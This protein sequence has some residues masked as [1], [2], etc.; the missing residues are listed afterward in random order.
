MAS[1]FIIIVSLWGW[2]AGLC[3]L[4]GLAAGALFVVVLMT[5]APSSAELWGRRGE[6]DG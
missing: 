6:N 3:F 2:V 4:G 5:T 1:A